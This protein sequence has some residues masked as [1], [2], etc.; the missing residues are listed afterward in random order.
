MKKI[1]S[2][3][4]LITIIMMTGACTWAPRIEGKWIS[5]YPYIEFDLDDGIG[6]M[7]VDGERIE[8][9]AVL[10]QSNTSITLYDKD[11]A[12]RFGYGDEARILLAKIKE[13]KDGLHLKI[14]H[15]RGIEVD[16]EIVMRKAEK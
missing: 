12:E 5:D 8:I 9:H 2:V 13:E 16:V 3:F 4:I 6:F 1:L 14:H 15:F 11:F 10:H 7:D